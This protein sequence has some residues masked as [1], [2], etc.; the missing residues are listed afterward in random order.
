MSLSIVVSNSNQIPGTKS[1]CIVYFITKEGRIFKYH[2][3]KKS[4]NHWGGKSDNPDIFCPV[5][6]RCMYGIMD[7]MNIYNYYLSIKIKSKAKIV[8]VC[9][10]L[11]YINGLKICN[12]WCFIL[13]FLLHN[14]SFMLVLHSTLFLD[15]HLKPLT[16]VCLSS[17]VYENKF[18]LGKFSTFESVLWFLS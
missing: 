10:S 2:Y 13:G 1:S 4:E 5:D 6:I 12:K 3:H 15:L 11:V 9:Y 16:H 18:Y 17:R 8:H 7:P 14:W